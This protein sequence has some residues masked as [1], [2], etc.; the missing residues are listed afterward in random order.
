M[1]LDQISGLHPD[2]HVRAWLIA[3]PQL[4]EPEQAEPQQAGL[5]SARAADHHGVAFAVQDSCGWQPPL[6]T[7][8]YSFRLRHHY[9]SC[10]HMLP[11][12]HRR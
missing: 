2:W 10:G 11:E 6:D 8:G 7:V 9:M 5:P 1:R 4:C 12:V 3:L